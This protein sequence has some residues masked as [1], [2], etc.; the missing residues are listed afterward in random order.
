LDTAG[1]GKFSLGVLRPNPRLPFV[2]EDPGRRAETCQEIFAIQSAGLAKRLKH[3][4]TR[5]IVIGI[6]GGLDSTLAL[7]VACRTFD[8]LGY[9]R[10]G[11]L[12]PTLPGDGTTRRTRVNAEELVHRLGVTLQIIP[13]KAAVR[14]HLRDIGH[15]ED[16]HDATYENVQARERTQLL[17]DL[18]NQAGGLVVGTGDLSESALGWCT[19][20]GD[21][22][23]MYHVNTGV[24]KTLVRYL[25]KW[26]SETEFGAVE[27]S[28][29]DILATPIT[30]ELIPVNADGESPQST[31]VL[32]GPFELHDFFLYHFVRHGSRPAKI[33][34]LA[35]QAFAG[36]YRRPKILHWMEVFF[37]RFFA[38]Q[39]KRSAHPDGP[40]VGSV[41]L[42]PRGDWR[43]PSDA[44][45]DS[46]LAEIAR[47]KSRPRRRS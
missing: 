17:M 43:M 28:L 2:P 21:H 31:E 45:A 42:S 38:N 40:K 10:S 33:L 11:I 36:T 15:D 34:V 29:R 32:V 3:V 6:S 7:L 26:C 23:S 22:M 44:S 14:Q 5:R 37:R 4:G 35:E 46:W 27:A 12:A 18:A 8:L 16:R 9:P 24:P 13:I 30:P 19:F 47:L 25:I 20:N 39:F 1:D 41:A